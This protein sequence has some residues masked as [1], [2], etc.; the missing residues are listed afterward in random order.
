[1]HRLLLTVPFVLFSQG[2]FSQSVFSQR[3]LSRQEDSLI[4]AREEDSLFI[5]RLSDEV[6]VNSKAYENLRVLTRTIGGRLSGSPQM[7]RAEEW[8]RQALL[9]AGAD[10]AYLQECAVPHWI[11]GGQ[12]EASWRAAGSPEEITMDILSLGNSKGTGQEGISA[13]VV[14]ISSFEE[15]QEKRAAIKGKIVFYNYQFDPHFIETFRSYSDAVRYRVLGASKAARYGAVAVLVRSISQ[16]VD[17]NPHAGALVYD[18]SFPRIPAAA[19]GLRDADR[20]ALA[21]RQNP[22]VNVYLRT[23]AKMLPDTLA[24][25]VIGEITGA[26]F[27]GQI[28]TVGAHLDSWDPGEGAQDDGAGCVHAIEVLRALRAVG[29]RPRHTI[30]I[31]LFANEENGLRGASRYAQ[32]AFAKRE[33][34]IFALESDAGGFTPRG[35][36][37]SLSPQKL[38]AITPWLE[39]LRPYGPGEFAR[40]GGGADVGPLNE[41]LGTTIAELVPDSQRYFD[42]HHA[43]NDVFAN[44]N[45]R[46][47]ELGAL[48]MAALIYLVDKY[49]A[50]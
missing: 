18:D 47:L 32:E 22:T 39:L 1:M 5:G 7:Y 46:E 11:R 2:V 48:S 50:P 13:P 20:L 33:Q 36:S 24:H 38:K 35:F 40:G 8:G 23:R 17:N 4:S 12:D 44:V 25:N 15:L 19:I 9:D 16:S 30:R 31:V 26:D 29:Y 49:G 28:I 3:A 41:L 43:R 14:L 37:F 21:I 45:K 10:R 34:H 42:Y 27:P 6:L